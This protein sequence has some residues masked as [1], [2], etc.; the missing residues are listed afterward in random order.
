MKEIQ[1]N[2]VSVVFGEHPLPKTRT[3]VWILFVSVTGL[4]GKQKFAWELF[5]NIVVDLVGS[6]TAV[7]V[8]VE[9]EPVNISINENKII[10]LRI[11]YV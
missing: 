10:E 2:V 7:E 1:K 4:G 3:I 8:P 5:M 9:G 6:C 11:H